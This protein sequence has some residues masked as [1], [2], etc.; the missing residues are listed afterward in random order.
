M[1]KVSSQDTRKGIV[2]VK[3]IPNGF[4]ILRGEPLVLGPVGRE[5][6][7]VCNDTHPPAPREF[8]GLLIIN[9]KISFK[10]RH[11]LGSPEI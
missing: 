7:D 11:Y 1:T 6:T 4:N 8:N 2:I 9:V 3:V 10:S 5:L